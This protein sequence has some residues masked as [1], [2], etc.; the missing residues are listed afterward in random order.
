MESEDT[1]TTRASKLEAR[2]LGVMMLAMMSQTISTPSGPMLAMHFLKQTFAEKGVFVREMMTTAIDETSFVELATEMNSRTRESKQREEAC[3]LREDVQ[4][5]KQSGIRSP[6]S[7]LN[8]AIRRQ[9]KNKA[10]SSAID[11]FSNTADP[12]MLQKGFS[13]LFRSVDHGNRGFISWDQLS[14]SLISCGAQGWLGEVHAPYV[15]FYL[16]NMYCLAHLSCL[17]STTNISLAIKEA[18]KPQADMNLRGRSRLKQIASGVV[19]NNNFQKSIA[20]SR[21]QPKQP[22][23]MSADDEPVDETKIDTGLVL[24][25]C[26][27]HA[28]FISQKNGFKP[29]VKF[30]T[31]STDVTGHLTCVCY[32]E[33]FKSVAIGS[34]DCRV[35]FYES[36]TGR[37]VMSESKVVLTSP[38]TCLAS[39]K[40]LLVVGC[41]DGMIR[42]A[43]GRTGCIAA[44]CD[45]VLKGA[46]YFEDRP[47]TTTS[48]R[49]NATDHTQVTQLISARDIGVFAAFF[50]GVIL[51]IDPDTLSCLKRFEKHSNGVTT[52]AFCREYKL[53]VSAGFGWEVLLWMVSWSRGKPFKLVDRSSPHVST[54][55]GVAVVPG[56]CWVVSADKRGLV[57]VWDGRTLRCLQSLDIARDET[58]R[59]T[60]KKFTISSLC[61]VK[62]KEGTWQIA[63]GG[64][65][66]LWL[67]THKELAFRRG[68]DTSPIVNVTYSE[69][70]SLFF[71]ASL[72]SVKTWDSSSG[73]LLTSKSTVVNSHVCETAT[74]SAY[75]VEKIGRRYIVGYVSGCVGVFNATSGD[76]I[77]LEDMGSEV[78]AIECTDQHIVVASLH[79]IALLCEGTGAGVAG[80]DLTGNSAWTLN[81]AF[82]AKK[83][84]APIINRTA[85]ISPLSDGGGCSMQT[86]R[87]HFKAI[88]TF[89]SHN[90][91]LICYVS[92]HEPIQ[93]YHFPTSHC[94]TRWGHFQSIDSPSSLGEP[95]TV[96]LCGF[97]QIFRQQ[98]VIAGV[99]QTVPNRALVIAVGYSEGEL[100]IWLVC[101]LP[102]ITN[103]LSKTRIK[104]SADKVVVPSAMEYD[105]QSFG[106]V[107]GGDAGELCVYNVCRV[108]R[109]KP[110]WQRQAHDAVVLSIVIVHR[111][112]VTSGADHAVRIWSLAE[113]A[114]IVK[115]E[116]KA[117]GNIRINLHGEDTTQSL[118]S[119]LKSLN[120]ADRQDTNLYDVIKQSAEQR[121][122]R[123][124]RKLAIDTEVPGEDGEE[125]TPEEGNATLQPGRHASILP[126]HQ[127]QRSIMRIGGAGEK[128]APIPDS[129]RKNVTIMGSD[130]HQSLPIG[131]M[132]R[133]TKT[134]SPKSLLQRRPSTAQTAGAPH[135]G[136]YH[137]QTYLSGASTSYSGLSAFQLPVQLTS[138]DLVR[139]FLLLAN[140]NTKERPRFP[141]K[142]GFVFASS[143]KAGKEVTCASP[144][145]VKVGCREVYVLKLSIIDIIANYVKPH[146]VQSK[147]K[148]M[149]PH[150]VS[151]FDILALLHRR[152]KTLNG[153][154]QQERNL[155]STMLTAQSSQVTKGVHKV[156]LDPSMRS[157]RKEATNISISGL[158]FDSNHTTDPYPEEDA[159][160]VLPMP[161]ADLLTSTA[162]VVSIAACVPALLV[163]NSYLGKT[164]VASGGPAQI[165]ASSATSCV[166]GRSAPM[167][168]QASP[169]SAVASA[170]LLRKAAARATL[171][172]PKKLSAAVRVPHC[173]VVATSPR[174]AQPKPTHSVFGGTNED[175]LAL[176][177]DVYNAANPLHDF[178]P[179]S[180]YG[181]SEPKVQATEDMVEKEIP[182]YVQSSM[183]PSRAKMLQKRR[184]NTESVKKR[185]LSH[186]ELMEQALMSSKPA[187]AA[188]PRC[189]TR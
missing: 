182:V 146:F 44:N 26:K 176:Q 183:L 169:Q 54:V 181:N 151:S 96:A 188:L 161:L 152:R 153:L 50:S 120:K 149:R 62:P 39:T 35:R 92:S 129:P 11:E 49:G 21:T 83:V 132:R 174:H 90:T 93:I 171:L 33:R 124:G 184:F 22:S 128:G 145:A 31:P 123:S 160:E 74:V 144:K 76:L 134:L 103:T 71:T 106:L 107:L 142:A 43:E 79:Q 64:D 136:F 8:S 154:Q 178:F 89:K 148:N 108:A 12:A 113:G 185:K 189:F 173:T 47:T 75:A 72:E 24:S 41:R 20:T 9:S 156:R 127:R 180:F 143:P 100:L 135:E 78:V 40:N 55:V 37:R 172:F 95:T 121:K 6:S 1:V 126:P 61:V 175:L 133:G 139:F 77:T 52:L 88:K 167:K 162:T 42:S 18:R 150:R 163:C 69:F 166:V 23:S 15:P 48:P 19:F 94:H 158:L 32:L 164:W 140:R 68:T 104:A 70:S 102:G 58:A 159:G 130:P 13:H 36:E 125:D 5:S 110:V 14:M 38:P 116:P 16:E 29:T 34:T 115:L 109:P 137:K 2:D 81:I 17:H 46:R 60:S 170:A 187:G 4:H 63:V 27:T 131:G 3:L 85:S 186:S 98:E 141:V 30:Q 66:R 10:T 51:L 28:D 56:N 67:L 114:F 84:S 122:Q 53:L 97:T 119:K 177:Q 105:A 86:I 57:K 82:K 117:K 25:L 101:T 59:I 80:S 87:N 168:L 118:M 138:F 112:V 111:T 179:D 91:E 45:F 165:R 73:A 155:Q 99:V 147:K 65:R 157:A 7:L